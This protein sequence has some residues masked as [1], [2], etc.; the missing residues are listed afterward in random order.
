MAGSPDCGSSNSG[1]IRHHAALLF[2]ESGN[3]YCSVDFLNTNDVAGRLFYFALYLNLN[4]RHNSDQLYPRRLV[5]SGRR[6]FGPGDHWH[7]RLLLSVQQ[8]SFQLKL[9]A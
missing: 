1:N 6:S 4:Y 5:Q 7:V 2:R 8:V 3:R 9:H